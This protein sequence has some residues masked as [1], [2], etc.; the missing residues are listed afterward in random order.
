MAG[1][2][3]RSMPKRLGVKP[4]Q[5]RLMAIGL[6]FASIPYLAF[7]PQPILR[8]VQGARPK[9]PDMSYQIPD[10]L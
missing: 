2:K 5:A 3:G 1:R 8:G 7:A 10:R 4:H 6:F 9:R